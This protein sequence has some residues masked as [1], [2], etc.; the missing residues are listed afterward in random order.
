MICHIPMS[1]PNL[2]SVLPLVFKPKNMSGAGIRLVV[3]NIKPFNIQLSIFHIKSKE[4]TFIHTNP[5][6]NLCIYRYKYKLIY[7][8]CKPILHGGFPEIGVP[9]KSSIQRWRFL[10]INQP[11]IGV[12]ILWKPHIFLLNAPCSAVS[13]DWFTGNF[14]GTPQISWQKEWFPV[15]IFPSTNPMNPMQMVHRNRR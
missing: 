12:P 9:P 7:N 5:L 4:N 2:K 13:L 1:I 10:E 11:A 8:P 3:L 6:L 14:T 15:S